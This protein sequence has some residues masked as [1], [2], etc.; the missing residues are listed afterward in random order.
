MVRFGCHSEQAL[1]AQSGIW[2]SRAK[3]RASC[4]AKIARLARFFI[5]LHHHRAGVSL[6]LAIRQMIK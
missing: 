5:K 2:A 6:D 1:F 4:K 3:R